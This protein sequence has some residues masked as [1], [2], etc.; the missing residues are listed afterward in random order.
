MEHHGELLD[1]GPHPILP[2]PKQT[3]RPPLFLACGRTE[4]LTQATELGIGAQVMGFAGP[5]A[6]AGMRPAYDAAIAARTDARRV[7]I[8][9]QRFFAQSIGH[10]YGGA[11]VPDEAVVEGADEATRMCARPP[12]R[13]SPASTN[14]TSRYVRPPPPRSTP[15]TRTAR[16]PLRRLPRPRRHRHGRRRRSPSCS[17]GV[18]CPPEAAPRR[19]SRGGPPD[20]RGADSSRV[21]RDPRTCVL[22]GF[23]LSGGP[24]PRRG[25]ASRSRGRPRGVPSRRRGPRARRRTRRP[26]HRRGQQRRRATPCPTRPRTPP[27]TGRTPPAASRP[28][29]TCADL[30]AIPRPGR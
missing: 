21:V 4:T 23:A 28:P 1:I 15:T 18:T 14:T 12:S 2:R 13:P 8:R 6:I 19:R 5:E 10:C 25:A 3:P 26:R 27:P 7:G 9:G 16:R 30:A 11:G 17:R 20:T 24:C 29:R 22:P